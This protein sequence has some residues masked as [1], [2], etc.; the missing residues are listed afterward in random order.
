MIYIIYVAQSCNNMSHLNHPHFHQVSD[1]EIQHETEV[2]TCL[3]FI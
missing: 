2:S 3:N 1:H